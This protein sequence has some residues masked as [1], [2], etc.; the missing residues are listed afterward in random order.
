MRDGMHTI[1]STRTRAGGIEGHRCANV[2]LIS[3][4]CDCVLADGKQ[5]YRPQLDESIVNRI[6]I[7]PSN[8]ARRTPLSLGILATSVGHINHHDGHAR[9]QYFWPLSAHI[10]RQKPSV[11]VD[12]QEAPRPPDTR[13]HPPC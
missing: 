9:P 11:F 12:N 1:G 7:N 6:V 13:P 3:Y 8:C 4:Y 2:P 5:T 10:A